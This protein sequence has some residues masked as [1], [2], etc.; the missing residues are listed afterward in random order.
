MDI[1]HLRQLSKEG[2][3]RRAEEERQAEEKRRADVQQAIQKELEAE[4]A[5]ARGAVEGLNAVIQRAAESGERTTRV[6]GAGRSS[7]LEFHQ[8]KWN[9]NKWKYTVPDYAQ[10]VYDHCKRAGLHPRWEVC[11]SYHPGHTLQ[12]YVKW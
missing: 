3:A 8:S 12:L 10:Y 2:A 4:W 7:F 11:Y 9:P 1:S 6:Y 5:R